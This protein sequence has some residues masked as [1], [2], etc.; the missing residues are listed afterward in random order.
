MLTGKAGA[1]WK[2]LKFNRVMVQILP[3]S[4]HQ[5]KDR[6]AE[7]GLALGVNPHP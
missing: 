3:L 2:G 4:Q 5:W 1:Q 6:H 7:G